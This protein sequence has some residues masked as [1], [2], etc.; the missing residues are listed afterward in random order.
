MLLPFLGWAVT[1]MIFFV[2]PG[3]A[4]A[5]EILTAKTYP[6]EKTVSIAPNPAWREFRCLR[7]VLGDHLI[8]RTDHGWVH[9]NPEN[10][11]PRAVPSAD[12]VRMLMTDA[13]SVN[14]KR[15]GHIISVVEGLARTDTNIEIRLDWKSL[16][17]QQ[18]GGDTD[19]LD[20]F[21]KIHYLQWT[22]IALVDKVLG[23]TGLVLVLV[24][25]ALGARLAIRPGK[26]G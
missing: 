7:T 5:Y 12:E 10:V 9:L 23:F 16:T 24:L 2:K 21:Y 26:H 6:L 20:L 13:I 4:G 17:L 25:T 1:G 3:Y 8:A 22:G 11:Q 15:Y 19:L 18:R 14:P